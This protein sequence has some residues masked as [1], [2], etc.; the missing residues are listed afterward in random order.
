MIER[1]ANIQSLAIVDSKKKCIPIWMICERNLFPLLDHQAEQRAVLVWF[2]ATSNT[3]PGI[4]DYKINL[5]FS[6]RGIAIIMLR[7]ALASRNQVWIHTLSSTWATI[8]FTVALKWDVWTSLQLLWMTAKCRKTTIINN[9]CIHLPAWLV[10]E[11]EFQFSLC[12]LSRI[13]RQDI[14]IFTL[15]LMF[16]DPS[17][18]QFRLRLCFGVFF[19]RLHEVKWNHGNKCF[20]EWNK[21]KSQHTS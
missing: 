7:T 21:F 19:L 13:S 14:V 16:S 18:L 2:I 4:T 17:L 20:W 3:V 12:Q 15:T 6:N 5:H 1:F 11:L 10:I 8:A 9:C